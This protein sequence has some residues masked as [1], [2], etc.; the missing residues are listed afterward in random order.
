ME[1]SANLAS[2]YPGSP[3]AR[4]GRIAIVL[5]NL[6]AIGAQRYVIGLSRQLEAKG[7]TCEFLV[8]SPQG[9]FFRELAPDKVRTFQYRRLT[10]VPVLRTGECVLRLGQML[11]SGGYDHVFAVTPFLNRM[12]CLL[13]ALRLFDGRVVIEEHGFP[14]LYIRREDGMGWFEVQFYGN[15][16]GLY[17]CA[18]AIRVISVGILDYYQTK[19]LAANVRLFP[20]LIDLRR[21]QNLGAEPPVVTLA[22]SSFHVACFGRLTVQ[23]NVAFLLSSMALLMSSMDVH[24]S[25]IGDGDQRRPLERLAD[26]LG[27]TDRVTFMGYLDNPYPVLRQA[28]VL[29]LTSRWEGSPQVLVEAMALGVAVVARDCQTGP[30]E[31]VGA[32]SERGWLVPAEAT[33][34]TFAEAV[35]EALVDSPRRNARTTAAA[36]FV[37]LTYDLHT[38]VGEQIDTFFGTTEQPNDEPIAR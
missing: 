12:I 34:A 38:R 16:F 26:D 8:Q 5:P 10:G 33:E 4:R 22:P 36:A 2:R 6:S 18:S 27:I 9:E 3:E 24:L 35:R 15:T 17:R 7:F 19:G 29:A 13:K 37:E 1:V 11:R 23:K 25:I 14:P 30:S 32:N 28:S 31:I 21:V 20:N